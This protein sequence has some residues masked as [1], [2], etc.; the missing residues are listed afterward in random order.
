MLIFKT[1]IYILRQKPEILQNRAA[2]QQWCFV[3]EAQLLWITSKGGAKLLIHCCIPSEIESWPAC[4][5]RVH[6]ENWLPYKHGSARCVAVRRSDKYKHMLRWN[7]SWAPFPHSRLLGKTSWSCS[8]SHLTAQLKLLSVCFSALSASV[9][10]GRNYN[11]TSPDP[12][13]D[14]FWTLLT[15]LNLLFGLGDKA[16]ITK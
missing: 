4:G 12:A 14:S 7:Q 5:T 16:N 9:A 11:S 6:R 2:R 1:A 10:R 8:V 3:G 13:G 15:L